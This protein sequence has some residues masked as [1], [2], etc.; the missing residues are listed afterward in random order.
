MTASL[1]AQGRVL[2]MKVSRTDIGHAHGGGVRGKIKEFSSGARRRMM[3]FF[4]RTEIKGVRITFVTLTFQGVQ[5]VQY[6]KTCLRRLLARIARKYPMASGV[7]RFEYQDRGAPHFHVLF[8]NLPYWP[9]REFQQVWTSCTKED[10]S[11]VDIRLV[12]GAKQVMNYVSKYCAKKEV[13]SVSPSLEEVTY[14]HDWH[15]DTGGKHWGFFNRAAIPMAE[16]VGGMLISHPVIKALSEMAWR[17]IGMENKYGSMSFTLFTPF[18]DLL[19]QEALAR[20]GLEYDDLKASYVG[21]T[22]WYKRHSD[23]ITRYTPF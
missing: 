1:H 21:E 9:Q 8:Y 13:N 17:E 6:A 23:H 22:I 14:P 11:I 15:W 7:W 3:E 19:C 2:Q 20:G 5:H 10:R 4:A 12:S 16:I 18:A